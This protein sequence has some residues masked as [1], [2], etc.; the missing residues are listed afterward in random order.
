VIT[1]RTSTLLVCSQEVSHR[2]FARRP[3]L[4]GRRGLEP[5]ASSPRAGRTPPAPE[6]R[7]PSTC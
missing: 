3:R 2:G 7:P 6:R 4:W 5:E 1:R